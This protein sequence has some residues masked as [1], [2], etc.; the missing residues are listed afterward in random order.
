M[1][2]LTNKVGFGRLG[3]KI[4]ELPVTGVVT[5]DIRVACQT[6]LGYIPPNKYIKGKLIYLT[7]LWQNFQELIVD[8]DDVV[9]AQHARA[10]IMML[11]GGC[12]MSDTSEARVHFM[13]LFLLSNF[14][15]ARHYNC[16]KCIVSHIDDLSDKELQLKLR[17]PL[18][19]RWSQSMSQT[20]IPTHAI[21]LIRIIFDRL[22]INKFMWT[23]Y[24]TPQIR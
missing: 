12:L 3:L 22:Q 6:L 18:K 8:V 7:W 9:I 2:N 1:K 4:D 24:E 5:G 23:S 17:F 20:N 21:K 13:Y 15:E 19:R 14:T 16:I 10:H 11:I